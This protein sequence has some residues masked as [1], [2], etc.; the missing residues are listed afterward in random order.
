MAVTIVTGVV[1]D[2]TPANP[3]L[4]QD[5][6]A[7]APSY[8]FSSQTTLGIR[9]TGANTLALT[10]PAGSFLWDGAVAYIQNDGGTLTFGAANDLLLTRDAAN[11]LALKNANNPQEF[12]AYGGFGGFISQV[13]ATTELI[14]I[15]AAATTASTTSI[16][17]GAILLGASVR[18]VTVIPTA[19]TFTVTTTAGATTLNTAA[20][21]TAAGSTDPGTAAGASYRSASTTITITPNLTPAAATGQV[22]LNCYYIQVTAPTS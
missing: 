8:S 17:A 22:R 14:T 11:T 15:A 9:R 7:T 4:A 2:F 1:A 20:V 16:P 5:G 12:R 19:A 18:V 3:V 10:A 21:S 13:K 6:S